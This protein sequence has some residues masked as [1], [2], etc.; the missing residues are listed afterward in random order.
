MKIIVLNGSPKGVH[1]ITLQYVRFLE[2]KYPQHAFQVFNVAHDIRKVES[3]ET[4]FGTIID[5]IKA[6]DGVIWAFPL[7]YLLVSAQYKR[8]VELIWER[9][10]AGAFEGKYTAA[11]STSI[12][13]FDHTA[14]NYIHGICDD[15][16]MRFLGSYSADMYDLTK[17]TEQ[18]RFLLFG[19]QFLKGIEEGVATSREYPPLKPAPFSYETHGNTRPVVDQGNKNVLILADCTPEQT[20]LVHMVDKLQDCFTNNPQVVNLFDVEMKGGCLGCI[21]C[22][23][24]NT[25]VYDGKDGFINFFKETV[26]QADIIVFA[27]AIRDRYLSSRWKMF[28]D[29]SFFNNHVPSLTGKQV[30]FLV[31]G[32]LGQIPNLRQIFEAYVELQKGNLSGI[33]TDEHDQSSEIDS[34]IEGLASRLVEY[35]TNGY[36][37]PETFF[38]TG[39]RKIFRDEIFGSM[40]FPFQADHAYYKKHGFYDFPQKDLKKRLTSTFLMLL[41]KIPA[42]RREIYNK[43]MI[44]EMVKPVKKVVEKVT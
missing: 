37:K 34:L 6:A 44:E 35:A 14:H 40:R 7:Y 38:G 15:L 30:G 39:G 12:H 2:K 1:S 4:V 28:F 33:V 18:Q 32:P 19:N 9:N 22:G 27:G 25:C 16:E 21:R 42:M 24:D 8:F 29:R 17:E 10:V 11:I 3:D 26:A 20:S 23:Y 31:S 13:L 36:I 41:T 43:R 5:G